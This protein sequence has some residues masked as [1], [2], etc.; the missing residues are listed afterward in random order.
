MRRRGARFN[1]ESRYG[2]RIVLK[3]SPVGRVDR[4]IAHERREQPLHIGFVEPR[5]DDDETHAA[6]VVRPFRQKARFVQNLSNPLHDKRTIR[7][8][9]QFDNA[10][11][12]QDLRSALAAQKVQKIIKRRA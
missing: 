9:L 5:T 10:F 12:P 6:R 8:P 3:R 1:G 11:Q 2:E 4:R 7:L